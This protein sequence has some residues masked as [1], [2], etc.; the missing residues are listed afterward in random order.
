MM[1]SGATRNISSVKQ[2]IQALLTKAIEAEAEVAELLAQYEARPCQGLLYRSSTSADH[3]S[4]GAVLRVLQID[5]YRE[6][7]DCDCL[8]LQ[9][10]S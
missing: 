2:G 1:I 4:L 5:F 8:W 10:K 7:K 6:A 3:I 9:R